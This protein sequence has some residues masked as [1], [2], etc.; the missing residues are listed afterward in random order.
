MTNLD[1]VREPIWV[2]QGQYFTQP[3]PLPETICGPC[4]CLRPLIK[5]PKVR[6]VLRGSQP[7]PAEE[8]RDLLQNLQGKWHLHHS[9]GDGTFKG[10]NFFNEA[11]ITENCLKLSGPPQGKGGRVVFTGKFN[12]LRGPNQEIY[13]DFLGGQL[14]KSDFDRGEVYMSN[15]VGETRIWRHEGM[16]GQHG[17]PPP[18]QGM[19]GPAGPSMPVVE[20]KVI[21]T[22]GTPVVEAQIVG[23]QTAGNANTGNANA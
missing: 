16:N 5:V 22:A 21:G 7:L 19:A 20:A 2:D 15:F 6:G 8:E 14:I 4:P 23:E 18:Q 10:A 12:F 9:M 11:V 13:T 3:F 1:H 17:Q